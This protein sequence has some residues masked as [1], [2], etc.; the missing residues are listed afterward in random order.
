MQATAHGDTQIAA[1]VRRV[2]RDAL[3]A[4]ALKIELLDPEGTVV[5][6][7]IRD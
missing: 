1:S 5:D 6:R 2:V 4:E 7:L 3:G